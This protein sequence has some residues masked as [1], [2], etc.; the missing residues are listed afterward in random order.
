[1]RERYGGSSGTFSAGNGD[2]AVPATPRMG[3]EDDWLP[4]SAAGSSLVVR[5]EIYVVKVSLGIHRERALM[6]G[7]LAPAARHSVPKSRRGRMA[8][9]DAG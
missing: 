3:E 8:I 9:S 4:P 6:T 1:M 2:A 7:T 5:F